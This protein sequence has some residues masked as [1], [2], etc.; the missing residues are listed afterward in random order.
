M[1]DVFIRATASW[2]AE[3][4]A[5]RAE[6]IPVAQRRRCSLATRI[7]AEVTGELVRGG[8]ALDHAAI[9][10]GT[11][12]GEIATT[13]ELLDMMH[14]G[15][16]ALSP[17]RFAGSVHNT[18]IG[19]LAIACGHTGWSTTVSAGQ[20][21]VAAA[22]LEALALLA[23]GTEHVLL[24]LSDEPLPASLQPYHD[25]LAVAMWLCRDSDA[26]HRGVAR[27]LGSQRD[28]PA[29]PRVPAST[30]RSPVRFAWSLIEALGRDV[31]VRLEPDDARGYAASIELRGP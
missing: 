11:A 9:V 18:A 23:C 13:V 19:Q 2:T 26:P 5:P 14:E 30:Q 7:V 16:G 10:H 17:L 28:T 31:R 22:W 1:N 29:E 20:H 25:G 24:V 8:L 4:G 21:T 12:L 27:W 15:D 6:L 3:R